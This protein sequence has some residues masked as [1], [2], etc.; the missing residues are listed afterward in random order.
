MSVLLFGSHSLLQPSKSG[1]G[2]NVSYSTCLIEQKVFQDLSPTRIFFFF[3]DNFYFYL[4]IHYVICENGKFW[5][6]KD[7]DKKKV[8]KRK[9]FM[10]L[11]SVIVIC[12][13]RPPY[14]KQEISSVEGCWTPYFHSRSA[15]N[16]LAQ[17]FL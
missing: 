1:G 5:I 15:Q 14:N 6:S 10:A 3:W 7:T 4:N 2:V 12:N 9:H 13:T 17:M 11:Q 16:Y 8:W